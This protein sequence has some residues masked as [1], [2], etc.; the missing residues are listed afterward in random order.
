[1]HQTVWAAGAISGRVIQ[2]DQQGR[3]LAIAGQQRRDIFVIER[4]FILAGQS[5]AKNR[6][7]IAKRLAG[8]S[9][10]AQLIPKGLV[11]E[12]RFSLGVFS[13]LDGEYRIPVH[14][15]REN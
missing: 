13:A 4:P 10:Q 9:D 8:R 1:M 15:D 14:L 11:G 3:Q 2:F 7:V 5:D 6:E 12:N